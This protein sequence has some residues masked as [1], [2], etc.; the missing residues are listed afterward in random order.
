MTR[1]IVSRRVVTLLFAMLVVTAGGV[2]YFSRPSQ[3]ADRTPEPK[4]P[5]ATISIRQEEFVARVAKF[6]ATYT[7]DEASGNIQSLTIPAQFE[8]FPENALDEI[9]QLNDL[10]ELHLSGVGI[11]ES[12]LIQ[13]AK[14][15]SLRTLD[16]SGNSIRASDFAALGNMPFLECVNFKNTQIQFNELESNELPHLPELKTIKATSSAFVIN[17]AFEF[18]LKYDFTNRITKRFPKVESLYLRFNP[19]F[20]DRISTSE[21][22]RI[23]SLSPLLKGIYLPINDLS[24][25]LPVVE[26]PQLEELELAVQPVYNA[27]IFSRTPNLRKLTLV[28]RFAVASINSDPI[29]AMFRPNKEIDPHYLFSQEAIS[30]LPET[31]K[32]LILASEGLAGQQIVISRL[33]DLIG[34]LSRLEDLDLTLGSLSM[35]IVAKLKNLKTLRFSADGL[36]DEGLAFLSELHQLQHVEIRHS[37]DTDLSIGRFI[38]EQNGKPSPIPISD[39]GIQNLADCRSLNSLLIDGCPNFTGKEMSVFRSKLQLRKLTIRWCGID[40]RGLREIANFTNLEEL[41]LSNNRIAEGMESLISLT[42]L[43]HLNLNGNRFISA[44]LAPVSRMPMLESLSLEPAP[45]RDVDLDYLSR[46]KQL[47]VLKLSGSKIRGPGLKSLSELSGL[48]ELSVYGEI[49][50]GLEHLNSFRNLRKLNLS[51]ARA[52]G[53][54]DSLSSMKSLEVL[55]LD[56][57]D[58][59]NSDLATIARLAHLREL[60]LGRNFAATEDGFK[61]LLDLPKLESFS[62]VRSDR[63]ATIDQLQ[64][65]CHIRSQRRFLDGLKR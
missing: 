25:R 56:A 58:L 62:V 33:P 64:A 13:I 42:K 59:D 12:H 16:L 47:R 65:N 30:V 8:R 26:Y 36:R 9:D 28:G 49:E 61:F 31:V 45:V 55:G 19:S 53:T 54:L 51:I 57:P 48:L 21:M 34:K 15:K 50:G 24:L 27:L 44:T 10:S 1:L 38:D 22:S 41:E 63:L 11:T 39:K 3:R 29:A 43:R 23:A 20:T 60:R 6:G 40:E 32:D 37:P 52:H 18:P 35:P 17:K 14:V 46:A 2:R 7:R 4:Q 5:N